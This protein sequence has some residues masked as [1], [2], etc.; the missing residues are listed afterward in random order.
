MATLL[1]MNRADDESMPDYPYAV[2]NGYLV[3]TG[4]AAELSPYAHVQAALRQALLPLAGGDPDRASELE[5]AGY[6]NGGE[7]PYVLGPLREAWAAADAEMRV[8]WVD[9]DCGH[10][11]S[12]KINAGTLRTSD[13][14]PVGGNAHCDE[15]PD[16]PT[17]TV[18]STWNTTADDDE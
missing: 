5:T 4:R 3:K 17:R 15:C 7:L 8:Q 6:D 13:A 16:R 9:L 2:D 18:T 12:K 1:E 10:F 11:F 14:Y